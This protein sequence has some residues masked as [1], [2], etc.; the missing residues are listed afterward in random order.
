MVSNVSV[1][2]GEIIIVFAN[3]QIQ[4]WP[5]EV[6]ENSV[7]FSFED[8]N[9][10]GFP[11]IKILSI[12]GI[13]NSAYVYY[14]YN[15]G[16]ERFEPSGY[17]MDEITNPKIIHSKK[18]VAGVSR[19]NYYIYIVKKIDGSNLYTAE[20]DYEKKQGM[21]K[22]QRDNC[23]EERSNPISKDEFEKHYMSVVESRLP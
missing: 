6:L 18:I 16:L 9:F 8:F 15:P 22:V 4:R 5:I 2:A 10:D 21:E 17:P 13:A 20:F 14:T 12:G 19:A 23:W 11:D 3:G 7:L 1:E